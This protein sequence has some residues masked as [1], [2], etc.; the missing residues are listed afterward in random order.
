MIRIA[1][2]GQDI[3]WHHAEGAEVLTICGACA[4][5]NHF[6][7]DL[8]RHGTQASR[9]WAGFD[10]SLRHGRLD[11]SLC[12]HRTLQGPRTM[13][14]LSQGLLS[15]PERPVQMKLVEHNSMRA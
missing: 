12:V 13:H 11:G 3:G 10:T 4:G 1:S 9:T 7:R 5:R 2:V 8:C 14:S 6:R 15:G